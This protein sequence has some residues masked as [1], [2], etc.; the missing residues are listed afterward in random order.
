MGAPA[1][2]ADTFSAAARTGDSVAGRA[3][4]GLETGASMALRFGGVAIGTR[5]ALSSRADGAAGVVADVARLAVAP[6]GASGL[7]SAAPV[8]IDA[9]GAV[10]ATGSATVVAAGPETSAALP[11]AETVAACSAAAGSRPPTQ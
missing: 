5:A 7:A 1:D 11:G 4:G 8:L 10:E 9:P 2:I 6:V 3:G